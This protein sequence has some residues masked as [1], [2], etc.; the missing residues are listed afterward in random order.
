MAND[1]L[2][3]LITKYNGKGVD[4]AEK[5]VKKLKGLA[6]K[7]L[8]GLAVGIGV[9][10]L[11]RFVSGSV[12]LAQTQAAAEA[13]VAAAIKSTGKAAGFSLRELKGYASGLQS[14]TNFGD[15]TVL[16]AQAQ[17]LTF[18]KIGGDVFPRATEAALDLATRMDGDLKGAIV[19]VGKALNDPIA[20]VTALTRSGV[21]FTD[22]QRDLIKELVESND[23]LGAQNVILAELETQFGGS[24]EAAREADGGFT[25]LSNS[26]G[27]FREQIGFLIKDLNEA[28]LATSGGG[29]FFDNLAV[30]IQS[31]RVALGGG[32]I[33]DEIATLES[34]IKRLEDRRRDM[35][36]GGLFGGFFTGLADDNLAKQQARLEEL[37]AQADDVVQIDAARVDTGPKPSE[38][39]DEDNNDFLD[40][41]R[42]FSK[43]LIDLQENTDRQFR[44]AL[45]DL[46]D[47]LEDAAE[48]HQ[49]RMGDIA[50]RGAKQRLKIDQDLAKSLAKA[51]RTLAKSLAK[52]TQGESKR[53][54]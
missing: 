31:V 8:A 53:I 13:Q 16:A 49:D 12:E 3:R 50:R 27:D 48:D 42:E 19:Q 28:T 54:D 2:I 11:A 35:P 37:K 47:G 24:A 21:Q 45:D 41:Q 32:D 52:V 29:T 30:G 6:A 39:K 51:D 25:S 38:E 46:N 40:L 22:Q 23:L 43:D 1:V 26:F 5:D 4:Q 18:T 15:E 17:L 33:N 36:E 20:G 34:T 44:D 9:A 14:V 7:T 10:E